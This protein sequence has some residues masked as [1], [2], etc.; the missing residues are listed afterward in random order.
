MGEE[1]DF[2]GD[3]ATKVIERFANVG[4]VVVGFVG[5][6]GARTGLME[7]LNHGR[8]SRTPYVT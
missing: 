3:S 7:N 8:V 5:V 6:L 2:V 4:R 1:I